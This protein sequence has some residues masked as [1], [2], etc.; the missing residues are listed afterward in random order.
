M[1]E[2]KTH[3]GVLPLPGTDIAPQLSPR[4]AVAKHLHA[5]VHIFYTRTIKKS[6]N[7]N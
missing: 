5:S 3:E 7:P 2:S 6:N 1:K 4:S